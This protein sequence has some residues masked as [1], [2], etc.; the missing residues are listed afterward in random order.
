QGELRGNLALEV[1]YTGSHTV[2]LFRAVDGNPP[3]PQLVAGLI[4]S[5]V[6]PALLAGS[7]LWTG[8]T[9]DDA[10]QTPFD[11]AVSN[12]AFFQAFLQKSI[13]SANYNGLK[14]RVTQR[15]WHGL[16]WGAAYTYAHAIDNASDPLTPA[17]GNRAFPRNSFNLAPERGNSDFDIRHRA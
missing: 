4:A 14:V 15:M 12:D 2:H 13:A 16:Q 6:D 17:A 9:N 5:G 10:A 11:P 3:Q 7:T 1:N 8:G